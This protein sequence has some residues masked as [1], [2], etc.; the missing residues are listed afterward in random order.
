MLLTNSS[1]GI[2]WPA[3]AGRRSAGAGGTGRRT[4][5][6]GPTNGRRRTTRTS[7]C[8]RRSASP[9]GPRPAPPASTPARAA[10][11]SAARASASWLQALLVVGVADPDVEVGVD[12]G[13]GEDAGQL[14]ASPPAHASAIVTVRSSGWLGQAAV[15]RA[16]K[17][18]AAA[19]EMLPGVLAV[20]DDRDERLSPAGALARSGGPPRPAGRRSRRPPRPAAQPE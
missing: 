7:R 15:E 17:R 11:S 20:E 14:R 18:P 13:A 3:A 16:Q 9:R 10:T 5:G 6:R 8:L 19:L 1:S 2:G 4:R 12:P